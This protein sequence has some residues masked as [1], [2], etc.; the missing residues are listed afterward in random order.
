MGCSGCGQAGV[1]GTVGAASS[2][3]YPGGRN[4]AASW[5]DSNGILWLFGGQGFD[6]AG[7][8]GD[9]N[10]LWEFV[11]SSQEWTWMGGSS[12]VPAAKTGQTGT[13]GTLGIPAIANQPGGRWGAISWADPGGNL[14]LF[15]GSGFDSQGVY[16][17]LND[18]WVYQPVPGTLPAAT[19]LL[20]VASGT[21]NATQI[22]SLSDP[23]PNATIY[24]T[25][26]GSIPTSGSTA[27]SGPITVSTSETLQA[28]AVASGYGSS[29]IAEANYK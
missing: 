19:P 3:I 22:V 9:L 17:S 18:L 20:S 6:S 24:Y 2:T 23:T 4:Q 5:T 11:P 26:D 28:I 27:Y 1:Y 25:A 8:Q 29:A 7:N 10:D 21:Y 15:G 14:W 16:D 13:Y 12:T